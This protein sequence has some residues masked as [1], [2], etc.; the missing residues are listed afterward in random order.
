[1]ERVVTAVAT[2]VAGLV[3][4]KVLGTAWKSVTGHE[5]PTDD[6]DGSMPIAEIVLFAAISSAL[7]AL[8][9]AYA[10]RGAHKWMSSGDVAR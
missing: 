4:N 7:V 8:V 5:P 6:K 1:M 3:A 9:R 10:S 2:I